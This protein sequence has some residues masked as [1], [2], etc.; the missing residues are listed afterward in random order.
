VVRP[1]YGLHPRYFEA[2]LGKKVSCDV[3]KGT[4]LNWDLVFKEDQQTTWKTLC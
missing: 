4:P 1:G 3:K 2:M